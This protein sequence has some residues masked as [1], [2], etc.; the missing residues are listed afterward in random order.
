MAAQRQSSIQDVA[1]LAGV[2]TATVSRVLNNAE[3]VAPD[4]AAKVQAAIKRLDY[5]P[6]LFAQGLMTRRSHVLGIALPDIHGEFYSELLRGADAE[7]RRLGYHLLVSAEA[8]SRAEQR[9]TG[10]LAFGL[11]DGLAVMIAEP[12]EDLWREARDASLPLV[13]LDTDLRAHGFDSIVV[14]NATGTREATAHLLSSVA[15]ERCYFVGGPRENFDTQQRAAAFLQTL[16]QAGGAAGQGQVVYGR[17]ALAWGQSWASEMAAGGTLAGAG[18][19]AGNDEIALGILQSAHE[20]GVRVPDDLRV[21]GFDDTRLASLVR[22]ALSAVRVPLA[23]VGSAAIRA[24]VERL[25][26]PDRAP[27]TV[28]L[29][30]K[31]VIRESSSPA[32]RTVA[33]N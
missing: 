10:S 28:S 11:I 12:N 33:R 17:Y 29:A 22:P 31:L 5:K 14:D 26:E 23:E 30:T 3:L 6:N 1:A 19:L 7:A 15:P 13:I 24:L 20:H 21:I 32:A 25:D 8:H 9:R 16:A 27:R 4:T 18:V 2:S